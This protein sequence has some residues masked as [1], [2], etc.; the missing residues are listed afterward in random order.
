MVADGDLDQ[1][2]RD[3]P[4]VGPGP[5]GLARL[6]LPVDDLRGQVELLGAVGKDRRRQAAGCRRPSCS[7]PC[8]AARRSP[9]IC[10]F[11]IV[12]FAASAAR[13]AASSELAARRGPVAHSDH[14]HRLHPGIGVPG[15]LAEERVGRPSSGSP[16]SS[17]SLSPA[18][19][20]FVLRSVPLTARS[21][22]TVPPFVTAI[23]APSS[24][25]TIDGI[26]LELG[27]RD[28]GAGAADRGDGLGVLA[29][30]ERVAGDRQRAE[31]ERDREEREDPSP[32]AED[33][34]VVLAK[35]ARHDC[36]C[37]SDDVLPHRRRRASATQG[38]RSRT[39]GPEDPV[40]P[41]RDLGRCEG[42]GRSPPWTFSSWN[43]RPVPQ[44]RRSTRSRLRTTPCSAATTRGPGR[45]RVAAST[46]VT[47][48]SSGEPS[49]SSSTSGAGRAPARTRSRM[50]SPARCAAAS[51][52]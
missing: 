23:E 1:R 16:M 36:S 3:L 35:P 37:R 24:T 31:A 30:G 38:P 6:D 13:S 17:V 4:V 41:A 10:C 52:W 9:S 19:S 45:S 48:R 50:G 42:R 12:L 15:H 49:R 26:D 33:L 27:Q 29:L 39:G 14:Q 5:H 51:R 11:I 46:P 40:S 2:A 22:S 34:A 43:P 28:L 7:G 47:A 25:I 20:I 44:T 32:Q 21:C 8:R 18:L